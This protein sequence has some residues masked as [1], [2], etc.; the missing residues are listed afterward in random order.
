MERGRVCRGRSRL[1]RSPTSC[2]TRRWST[3]MWSTQ[4]YRTK[5]GGTSPTRWPRRIEP[6]TQRCPQV[7]GGAAAFSAVR[8]FRK[9]LA[10]HGEA[11]L[12]F[13][14]R[15]LVLH[16]VPVLCETS[17]LYAEDVDDDPGRPPTT[18]EAPVDI[19][20]IERSEEHTSELQ[21]HSD[22]VCRLLLEKK[23]I[24]VISPTVAVEGA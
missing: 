23:R 10:E 21:S 2:S 13:S 17:S 11:A 7:E 9:R 4:A 16:D 24:M 18:R 20:R 3:W 8:S 15:R 6:M 5:V 14:L 19:L 22:L 12:R 1:A